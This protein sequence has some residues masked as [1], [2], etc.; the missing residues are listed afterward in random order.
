MEIWVYTIGSAL[1]VSLVSLVG[2]LLLPVGPR[3]LKHA[4]LLLVS[5]SA[6][7]LIGDTFIHILPEAVEEFGF[8]LSMS[9][10]ILAGILSFFVLEQ[11]VHWH[12]CHHPKSDHP[13]AFVVTN[14]VGDAL[15]NFIDGLFIAASYLVSIPLGIATTLA[16]TFHEIPQEMGDLG[17]LLHGG[18][19]KKKALFLNFVFALFALMGAIVGLLIGGGSDQF[20]RFI[21][22]FTAGGF[23]YVANAD[24]FPEL[25][26]SSKGGMDQLWHFLMILAGIGV[27]VLLLLLE[28]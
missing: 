24:L 4:V 17:V 28:A 21:L 7:A 18:L 10:S 16:V 8:D 25:H 12:H 27:M 26:K 1:L 14:L 3:F 9:L 15:H 20:L 23:L 22:P 11:F 2:M 19:A 5:F 6:G 13:H